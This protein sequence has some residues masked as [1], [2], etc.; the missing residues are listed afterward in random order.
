MRRKVTHR[1]SLASH[2]PWITAISLATLRN[3]KRCVP[4]QKWTTNSATFPF[5]DKTC[6]IKQVNQTGELPQWVLGSNPARDL[7]FLGDLK[8]QWPMIS[9]DRL[10]ISRKKERG[11]GEDFL[12]LILLRIALSFLFAFREAE[13]VCLLQ[14]HTETLAWLEACFEP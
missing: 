9:T 11:G 8:R 14:N 5:F 7:T 10:D 4:L 2:C 12:P 3:T 6:N 1:R 13:I